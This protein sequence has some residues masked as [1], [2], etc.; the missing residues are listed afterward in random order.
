M[1]QILQNPYNFIHQ[2]FTKSFKWT[3]SGSIVYES[4]KVLHCF[5]LLKALPANVYGAMGSLFSLIYLVTYIADLGATNSLPP[6][7]PHIA[8]SRSRMKQFMLTYSLMPHLP[9]SILCALGATYFAHA[10]LQ[11]KPF[12]IIIPLIIVLE[13]IRSFLRMFLH[14]IF[15]A[16]HAVI[17]ELIIFFTYT[18]VIW[19]PHLVLNQPI[20]LNSIFIPHLLDSVITV[21]LFLGFAHRYYQTLH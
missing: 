9:I 17:A 8:K 3:L 18:A 16:K 4:F 20:T 12:I 10:N 1:K 19:L 14:T 5:L 6:F 13:T 2:K 21:V 15:Y 11:L 7:L